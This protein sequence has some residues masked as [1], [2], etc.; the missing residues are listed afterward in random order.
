MIV[1][2][3]Q[4]IPEN[5]LGADPSQ[6]MIRKYLEAGG[7]MLWFGD[8]PK[9]FTSND[10]GQFTGVDNTIA[11]PLLGI[12]LDNGM[13]SGNYYAT[14]TQEG[15]NWGLPSWFGSTYAT[16]APEG[17]EALAINE[18]NMP[19]VFVK[20]FTDKPGTGFVSYRP[21]AWF[22]PFPEECLPLMKK[23]AL[24]GLE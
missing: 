7:K 12:K 21:W 20:K 8:I 3:Y 24:Y 4:Y 16:V 22:V 1:F 6:G 5:I 14:S 9:R 13:E 2:A 10:K 18:F 19:T 17:V 11:E 23:V 15:L